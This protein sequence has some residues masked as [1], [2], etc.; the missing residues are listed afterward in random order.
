MS[1]TPELMRA[2]YVT[3]HGPASQIRIGDLPV[4]AIGP[5]DVLVAAQVVAVCAADTFVRSG[6]FATPVPF[7]YIVGRDLAGEVAAGQCAPFA[8]G[9]RCGTTAWATRAS[10]A[11]SRS[12]R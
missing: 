10:R 2:A 8:A 3:E 5:A 1:K 11:V 7:P 12:S 4:P 9:D 6:Q